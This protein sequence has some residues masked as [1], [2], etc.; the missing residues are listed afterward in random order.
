MLGAVDYCNLNISNKIS[1]ITNRPEINK[2]TQN[3]LKSYN[4]DLD[5]KQ[6]KNS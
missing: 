5:Q 6:I 3:N 2:L 1:L 4:L